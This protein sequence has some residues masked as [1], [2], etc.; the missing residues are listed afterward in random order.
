MKEKGIELKLDY[1]KIGLLVGLECHQQLATR[2]KLFCRCKPHLFKGEPEVTF[3]RRLRPTQS[4]LGQVDPAAFFEFQKGVKIL[5]E[6]NNETSCLVEM[7]EEPPHELNREALEVALTVAIMTEANPVDEVHIM[8]KTVIDGSNTTGFQRTCVVALNGMMTVDGKKVPIQHISLEEDAAR[9]MGEEGSLIHYRIDRLGIPLIEVTTG[10]VITSPKEAEKVALAIGKILRA[11]GKV[12]RGIGTIRQDLNISIR[13]GALMEIKGVQELE[14]VSRVVEYEVQRQ[15]GLLSIRD[16]L[17]KRELKEEN[18]REEFI[19]VTSIFKQTNSRVIK[20][21]IDQNGCVLSARLP[22]FA[23]LLRAELGPDI[24]LG[25]EMTERSRFWGRVGGIFHTDELPAYGV[26][27]DEVKVLKRFTKAADEDCV[28]FV[29]DAKDRAIDALQAVVQRAKEALRGVPEETRAANP[30][31]T[32]HYMRPRP[33]AARMYPETD[34]PPIQISKSYLETLR[35]RLPEPPEEKMNRLM[36]EYGINEKLARQLL[37]SEYQDLFEFI[38][39]E[40]SVSPTVIAATLTE[41][42]K[43][44]KR[45]GV[46]IDRVSNEQILGVFKLIDSGKTTKEAWPEIFA[47]L[48]EHE[49][50]KTI[51]ALEQIGLTMIPQEELEAMIDRMID[52]NVALIRERKDKAFG[53]LMSMVMREVRGRGK[54]E[55]ISKILKDK[56]AEIM[57]K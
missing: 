9:K 22:K 3:L 4:E 40:V 10:P 6:A 37:D 45:D 1:D 2:G 42:L 19:E 25:K 28:V 18:I 53:M 31:G 5:Y 44:L 14:L 30:D 35:S 49:E 20:R 50:A 39:K 57:E 13:D 29:A 34:V 32:T 21:A 7:D 8:R 33:G 48:A 12:R 24:R 46:D 15:L 11:T 47:W 43:A 54:P 56:L 17:V 38:A 16:E 52:Q 23:G 26:T 36:R 41:T 27:E 55:T 51:E